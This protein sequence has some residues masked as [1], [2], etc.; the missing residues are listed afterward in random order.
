MNKK[1]IYQHFGRIWR[2][3]RPGSG[4]PSI[5]EYEKFVKYIA[6]IPVPKI[7]IPIPKES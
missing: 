6:T 1:I 2:D 4:K 3:V 5:T 7:I